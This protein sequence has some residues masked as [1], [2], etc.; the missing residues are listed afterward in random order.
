MIEVCFSHNMRTLLCLAKNF[1]VELGDIALFPDDLI[2]AWQ[3]L[4]CV[5]RAH[6]AS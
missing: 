3:P 2:S 4:S 5:H 1:G 6:M